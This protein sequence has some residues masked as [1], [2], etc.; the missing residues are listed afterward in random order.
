[1]IAPS[2][3]VERILALNPDYNAS[4]TRK[5]LSQLNAQGVASLSSTSTVLPRLQVSLEDTLSD[6]Q[7]EQPTSDVSDMGS[8]GNFITLY[9]VLVEAESQDAALAVVQQL[10]RT[11]IGW[12]PQDP[13]NSDSSMFTFY[14]GYPIGEDQKTFFYLTLW[15][16]LEPLYPV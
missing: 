12:K 15:R 1:M 16:V 5:R 13:Y 9:G 4:L 6:T 11:L 3:I 8:A 14:R 10:R 2:S 7:V